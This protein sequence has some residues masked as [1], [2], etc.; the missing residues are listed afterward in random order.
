MSAFSQ[1]SGAVPQAGDKVKEIM[2]DL[3]WH[4]YNYLN[5]GGGPFFW[6]SYCHLIF[7]MKDVKAISELMVKVLYWKFPNLLKNTP[8]SGLL[9]T[10]NRL[11]SC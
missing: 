9:I 1:K 7:H 5:P 6:L 2:F 3:L 10:N 8:Q 11:P 4:S